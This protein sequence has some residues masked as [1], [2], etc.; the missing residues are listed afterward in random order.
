MDTENNE[1]NTQEEKFE[2]SSKHLK[3]FIDRVEKLEEEKS[4]IQEDIKEIYGEAKSLGFDIK[5]L[6]SIVSLKKKSVEK[7]R[8]ESELL[9]LYMCAIGM[10]D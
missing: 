6:K 5:T 10:S 3:A 7:R 2:V 8:E 1:A 9:D 4:A